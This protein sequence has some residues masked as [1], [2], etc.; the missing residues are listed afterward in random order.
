MRSVLVVEDDR[1]IRE[2]MGLVLESEGY[3]VFTAAH[4]REALRLL[5]GGLRPHVILLDLMM[6]VMNG[7]EL[8]EQML[9]DPALADIPTI[10]ITGDSRAP[11]QTAALKA[12]A[13][14]VKPFEISDMLAVVA[15]TAPQASA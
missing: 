13:C 2:T 10:V 7:W 3:K 11:Q 9:G 15:E 1:D 12:A 5:R 14:I 4:G 8:R 6:P